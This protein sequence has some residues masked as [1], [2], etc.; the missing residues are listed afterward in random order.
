MAATFG[1]LEEFDTATGEDWIQYVERM[2][3][4]FQANGITEADTKRAVLISAMGGKAYKLMRNL[5]SPAKP[6]D[7]SFEQLVETMK[8]HFCPPPSEIVQR[9]KFKDHLE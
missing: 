5:I 7:K 8:K 3:Y 4:Y 2:E 9:Y 1:K 6:K